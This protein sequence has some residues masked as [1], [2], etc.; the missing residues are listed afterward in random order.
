VTRPVSGGSSV[1]RPGAGAV[2]APSFSDVLAALTR[3]NENIRTAPASSRLR[4]MEASVAERAG[5]ATF[6]DVQKENAISRT[7]PRT[8]AAAGADAADADPK[9]SGPDLSTKEARQIL[10]NA[11]NSDEI[12]S[13]LLKLLTDDNGDISDALLDLILAE[14]EEDSTDTPGLG[15]GDVSDQ[16]TSVLTDAK[17]AQELLSTQSGRDL[18]NAM[19]ERSLAGL[20]TA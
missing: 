1:Q 3:Q 18:V 8:A 12:P 5:A 4:A 10:R 13:D 2:P 15:D 14:E 9:S 17:Q 20:V 19:A 16:L 7:A 6:A 11:L